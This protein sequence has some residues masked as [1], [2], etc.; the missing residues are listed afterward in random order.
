VLRSGEGIVGNGAGYSSDEAI[1]TAIRLFLKK[2]GPD[3]AAAP[4]PAATVPGQAR[5]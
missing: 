2:Q 3:A 5:S 4:E 1:D